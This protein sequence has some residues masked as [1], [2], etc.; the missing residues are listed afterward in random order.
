MN[1]SLSKSPSFPSPLYFVN[2]YA[3]DLLLLKKDSIKK[4][5]YARNEKEINAYLSYLKWLK[6]HVF[7]LLT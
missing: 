4:I 1:C 2:T 5:G 3:A 7:F 6:L